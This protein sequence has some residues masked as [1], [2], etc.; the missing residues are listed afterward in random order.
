[1]DN[2]KVECTNKTEGEWDIDKIRV[3][4]EIPGKTRRKQIK[5]R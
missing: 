1:M 4:D 3:Q 5:K 2:Q